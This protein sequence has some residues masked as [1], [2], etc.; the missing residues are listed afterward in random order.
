MQIP[1]AP[2]QKYSAQNRFG[3][4]QPTNFP[5]TRQT[6]MPRPGSPHRWDESAG[7]RAAEVLCGWNAIEVAKETSMKKVSSV[8][9]ANTA[10]AVGLD[11]G[12]RCSRFCALNDA[13]EA[14]RPRPRPPP[15][16][17]SPH[18][19]EPGT[20]PRTPA[21]TTATTPKPSRAWCASIPGC[22][23]PSNIAARLT[24]RTWP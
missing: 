24:S 11:P 21:G 15:A 9:T 19:P 7:P 17:P 13:G 14:P 22:C 20:A 8:A 5:E 10:A 23:S 3:K 12:D 16:K 18:R 2:A 1:S 6:A 4:T